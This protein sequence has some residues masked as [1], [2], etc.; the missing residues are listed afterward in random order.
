MPKRAV[1]KMEHPRCEICRLDE[2]TRAGV[3]MLA[4]LSAA[5]WNI[6]RERVNNTFGLSLT[7]QCI[8]KHMT[9]HE[10]H[11]NAAQQGIILDAVR[12]KEGAPAVIS[13]ETMLQTLLVQ[14]MLDLA[15]GKIRCK[16]PAELLSVIN[17]IQNFQEKKEAKMAIEN[18]DPSAFYAVMAA[19]GTAIRD[20]VSRSQM[21]DIVAKANSLGANFNIGNLPDAEIIDLEPIDYM[22]ACVDDYKT[23]GHSR[24]R[25]ELIEAGVIA[26]IEA[27]LELP[28]GD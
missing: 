25:D 8:K 14:G 6:C 20:T 27:E 17:M 3:E 1:E 15:K 28:G 9:E 13:C 7:T 16:T 5:S 11:K 26:D 18:G 19:Y 21:L 4:M 24:T 2:D 23:Y 22:Q 12:D 10:L